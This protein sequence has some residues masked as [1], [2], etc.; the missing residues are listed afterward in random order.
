M[1]GTHVKGAKYERGRARGNTYR[2]QSDSFLSLCRTQNKMK[3]ECVR[4]ALATE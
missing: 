1:A 2:S 4:R 3:F